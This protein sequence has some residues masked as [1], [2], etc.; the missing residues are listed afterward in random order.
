[1]SKGYPNLAPFTVTPLILDQDSDGI[2]DRWEAENGLDPSDPTDAQKDN[3]GDG[4]RNLSEFLAGTDP[5]DHKSAFRII[6]FA[7]TEFDGFTIRWE[8]VPGMT[9]AIDSSKG[10]LEWTE[11]GIL[12]ASGAQSNLSIQPGDSNGGYFRVRVITP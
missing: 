8:S 5:N 2:D 7:N 6:G 9:Y 1:M 4:I 11:I 10:L 3:D 12:T